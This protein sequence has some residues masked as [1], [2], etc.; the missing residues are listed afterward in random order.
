V[1]SHGFGAADAPASPTG[2]G[3]GTLTGGTFPALA[4]TRQFKTW[5]A[6]PAAP[7]ADALD[8]SATNVRTVTVATRRAR[9]SCAPKLNV[10]SDGPLDVV[11]G[12]CGKRLLPRK[13]CVDRRKFSFRLH[14]AKR[15]RVVKVV[16]YVNGKRKLRRR[17]HSIRRITLR[18]LPKKRFKVRIEA[19]Q[20]TGGKLISTRTYRGCRKS[21]PHTRRG[22]RHR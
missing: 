15:A 13:R 12:D 14:H 22:G 16:V 9:V 11:L 21:R 6:P 1:L 18:R 10:K 3:G 2:F 8:I 19:T 5:G 20:S 7:K 17:G 4:F